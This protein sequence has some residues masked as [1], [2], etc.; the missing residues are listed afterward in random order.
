[1]NSSSGNGY[2]EL[3]PEEFRDLAERAA[4][5]SAVRRS[6]RQMAPAGIVTAAED[7]RSERLEN[8]DP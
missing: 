5:R 7:G 8:A 6:S 4:A 3:F 2:V 1:M